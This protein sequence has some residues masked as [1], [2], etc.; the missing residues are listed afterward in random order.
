MVAELDRNLDHFAQII[1]RDLGKSVRDIP[2]AGAAGGLGAGLVAFAGGRLQPGVRL[3]ID[4]VGLELRLPGADLCLTGEGALDASSVYGK[5]AV[6][7][8]L[9]ARSL[10]CPV[11]ALAGTI[12]AGAEGVL[13]Q[14][15][16]A[17]FSLCSHP[18][19]LDD[20][21]ANAGP[22]LEQ[23]RRFL[24]FVYGTSRRIE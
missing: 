2:G 8:A 1:E 14:G 6:G 4:A 24:I 16:T 18:M 23:A 17:Y 22:L 19:S 12:G 5:T 13:D 15:I 10:E 7:V 11:F 20:A 21:I 9:L 3:V